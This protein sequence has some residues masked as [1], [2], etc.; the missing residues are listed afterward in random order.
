MQLNYIF[1]TKGLINRIINSNSS[2]NN[3]KKKK[4][5][6]EKTNYIQ[7]INNYI[8]KIYKSLGNN[9]NLQNRKKQ[10]RKLRRDW[11]EDGPEKIELGMTE[12][13][14]ASSRSFCGEL[15]D[16]PF[17][18]LRQICLWVNSRNYRHGKMISFW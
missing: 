3:P 11:T 17:F 15:Q 7:S 18:P 5:K 10:G 14:T 13:R 6:I 4:T 2:F 9:L 12:S 8:V 1:L 16:L